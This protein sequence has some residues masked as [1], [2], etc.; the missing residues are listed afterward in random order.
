MHM[1]AGNVQ[2]WA[3]SYES[4]WQELEKVEFE[5][6]E[7]FA[8]TTCGDDQT[9][10][11]APCDA[12]MWIIA[13]TNI[14]SLWDGAQI[15][16]DTQQQLTTSSSQLVN[17]LCGSNNCT[18]IINSFKWPPTQAA[19]Q[20]HTP[21]GEHKCYNGW[22]ID[23]ISFFWLLQFWPNNHTRIFDLFRKK[24]NFDLAS[25]IRSSNLIHSNKLVKVACEDEGTT[26]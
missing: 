17:C 8:Q 19:H 24:M 10:R 16:D 20:K 1:F 2:L 14:Q 18:D 25:A 15:T 21:T 5:K 12:V 23:T 3:P 4:K 11:K 7:I 13:K 26:I 9:V 6:P 22:K